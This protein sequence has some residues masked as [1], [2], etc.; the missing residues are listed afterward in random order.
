M[1]YYEITRF[2]DAWPDMGEYEEVDRMVKRG[3]LRKAMRYM[4]EWDFGQE[5]L[6]AARSHKGIRDSV[7][8][9]NSPRDRIIYSKPPY[10]L[11]ESHCKSGLYDAYYLVAEVPENP[12]EQS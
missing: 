8:D 5:T 11:C 10:Y 6:D 12:T 2:A 4:S 3:W 1:Q 7:M 9:K